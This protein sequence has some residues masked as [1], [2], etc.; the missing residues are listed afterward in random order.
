MAAQRRSEKIA[1]GTLTGFT[2][3]TPS[4][5]LPQ[6][7]SATR[8]RSSGIP[9]GL[10]PSPLSE[11]KGRPRARGSMECLLLPRLFSIHWQWRGKLSGPSTVWLALWAPQ[12]SDPNG[13]NP[14]KRPGY[15][16][17][18]NI[19]FLNNKL[20]IH[21]SKSSFLNGVMRLP[22]NKHMSSWLMLQHNHFCSEMGVI[23][24][25]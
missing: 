7:L 10:L 16:V 6:T 3:S 5:E 11:T 18:F 25:S 22:T 17:A 15:L 8:R 2:R 12:K 14:P 21:I 24:S 20:G 23:Y 13:P 19:R 9:S 4:W 1:F